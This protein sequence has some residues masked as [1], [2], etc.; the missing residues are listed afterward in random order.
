MNIK[1]YFE[2]PEV[3]T[4]LQKLIKIYNNPGCW[5]RRA[6]DL[7]KLILLPLDMWLDVFNNP[8]NY[9]FMAAYEVTHNY[10]LQGVLSPDRNY[11]FY[12]YS[13]R[14][15]GLKNHDP[16]ETCTMVRIKNASKQNCYLGFSP[17]YQYIRATLESDR[18]DIFTLKH[19]ALAWE[20]LNDFGAE[21]TSNYRMFLGSYCGSYNAQ[22]LKKINADKLIS[23][24]LQKI[25]QEGSMFYENGWIDY[26]DFKNNTEM[27]HG[28]FFNNVGDMRGKVTSI[29]I[30]GGLYL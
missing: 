28:W 24:E 5:D 6:N 7:N 22:K 19:T 8:N 14:Y 15:T 26:L 18:K 9:G 29:F 27:K 16:E 17:E 12:E 23:D 11:F 1:K 2:K 3:T 10:E 13:P 20:I 25:L 4:Y 30:D 21:G